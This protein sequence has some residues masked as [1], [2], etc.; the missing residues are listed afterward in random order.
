VS[1]GPSEQL[2]YGAILAQLYAALHTHL[3]LLSAPRPFTR[4]SV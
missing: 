2:A 4:P 3:Q 1:Y